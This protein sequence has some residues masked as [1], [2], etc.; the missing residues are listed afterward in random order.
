MKNKSGSPVGV[1]ACRS[2][3]NDHE[4][5]QAARNTYTDTLEISVEIAIVELDH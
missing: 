2:H 5:P 4:L 1:A 3:A